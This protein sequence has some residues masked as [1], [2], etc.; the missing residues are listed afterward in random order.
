MPNPYHRTEKIKNRQDLLEH[1]DL[2]DSI[3]NNRN[4]DDFIS[5]KEDGVNK[6][7][8]ARAFNVKF[9]TMAHWWDIYDGKI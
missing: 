4:A 5:F 7:N 1:L 6:A 9:K 3:H 8:M 2:T